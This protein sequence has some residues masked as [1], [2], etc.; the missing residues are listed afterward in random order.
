MLIGENVLI[1]VEGERTMKLRFLAFVLFGFS[2]VSSDVSAMNCCTSVCENPAVRQVLFAGAQALA[3][4]IALQIQ[5]LLST[6]EAHFSDAFQKLASAAHTVEGW[7]AS[8]QAIDS[9]SGGALQ[10]LGTQ[11][12]SNSGL[13]QTP[14]AQEAIKAYTV[15]KTVGS[16]PVFATISHDVAVDLG[17]ITSVPAASIT[18]APHA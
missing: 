14:V 6:L 3:P 8:V 7:V 17:K 2:L 5:T 9:Q 13:L 12:L 11:I 4:E 18:N 10:K 1:L 16:N 15:A